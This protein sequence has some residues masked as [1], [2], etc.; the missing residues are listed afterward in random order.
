M[1]YHARWQR[2]TRHVRQLVCT[3]HHA[4]SATFEGVDE[5]LYGRLV[6]IG[7][8]A[9]QLDG[10][11]AAPRVVNRDVPVAAYRVP[12]LILRNKY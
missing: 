7:V 3:D 9:I 4:V 12:G 5:F 6:E 1:V 11:L 10:V 8:V 2:L